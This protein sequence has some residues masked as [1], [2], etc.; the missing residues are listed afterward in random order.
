MSRSLAA[1]LIRPGVVR[2]RGQ[3]PP[4]VK[5]A[6]LA[7]VTGRIERDA[8]LLDRPMRLKPN[9][10]SGVLMEIGGENAQPA[11]T[12]VSVLAR[13]DDASLVEA[14]PHTGRQH[15]IRLHLADAGHAIVGDKLYLGGESLFLAA[16]NHH[17]SPEEVLEAVGH[18]RQAL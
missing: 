8:L 17:V 15:Q 13:A 4:L 2:R 7:V 3:D 10:D 18:P 14:R 12:E 9:S 16:L 11:V 5:K 6:Y 1:T